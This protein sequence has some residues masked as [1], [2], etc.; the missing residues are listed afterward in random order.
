MS[1][2]KGH[3]MIDS[4]SYSERKHSETQLVVV[5]SFISNLT[6]IYIPFLPGVIVGLVCYML[7]CTC[8]CMPCLL[9]LHY[10]VPGFCSLTPSPFAS[11]V[12]LWQL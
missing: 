1:K 3:D 2:R 7:H 9:Y 11:S 5:V 8:F 12:R 6:N 4:D 10:S